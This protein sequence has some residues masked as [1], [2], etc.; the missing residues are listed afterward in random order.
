M[1]PRMKK[2]VGLLVLA[3]AV[4]FI[5]QFPTDAADMVRS[6]FEGTRDLLGAAAE[7]F[8]TFLQQLL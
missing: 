1:S 4:F 5:V 2:L 8:S 3:F 7:S 6:T